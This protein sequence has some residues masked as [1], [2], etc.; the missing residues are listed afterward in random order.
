VNNVA[1]HRHGR[2]RPWPAGHITD[3]SLQRVLIVVALVS[4]AV[5]VWDVTMGGF[6]VRI[7]GLRVVSRNIY[8]PLRNAMICF[9][10]ALWLRDR[11][12]NDR[13]SWCAV[14]RLAPPIAALAAI[15]SAVL[16]I[17]YG[18][19]AAG[20][21]DAFG[22]VSQS[23]LWASGR[24]TE[25]DSF[26]TLSTSLGRAV[27]P[28]GYTLGRTPGV[29]IPTYPPGLP[30]AMALG[31]IVGGPHGVYFVV[32]LLAG[33]AVW[34]TYLL[35]ARVAGRA[36]GATAALLL[37]S[38][39]IFIFQSFQPMSDVPATT[40]WLLS[41]ALAVTPATWA[42][43]AAGAAASAAVLTRPNLVP[44]AVVVALVAA[45]SP[46]RWRRAAFFAAAF[47]PGCVAIGVL[48]VSLY[49]SPL[50]SGYGPLDSL[51]AWNNVIA[52]AR[53][54]SSWLLD[55]QSP[56]ILLALAAPLVTRVKWSAAMFAFSAFLVVS[57]LFYG[58]FDNW[59]F[60]RFLLPAIPLLLI[61]VAAV[62]VAA[63]ERLPI[64]FRGSALFLVCV[65][66][67]GWCLVKADQLKAFDIYRAERRYVS[68]GEFI[69]S[70]L[71][72]NAVVITVIESG[73]VRLYGHRPTLRWDYIEPQRFDDAVALVRARG[74][75]P[76]ILLEFWEEPL[77]RSRFA[78]TSA[79]G[80]V[81]WPAAIQYFGVLDVRVYAV[82]DRP[83]YLTG[84]RILPAIVPL[85]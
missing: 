3:S 50:R 5:V 34:L 55:L 53:N 23:A 78:S 49:G 79:I 32:P 66:A 8:K 56:A 46:P 16:A 65:L 26:A 72:P 38:S 42:A 1:T 39:P 36:A 37:A 48:N 47:V 77:F 17:R 25:H 13:T 10:A 84:Q 12:A 35:G 69:G 30:L 76:Y 2:T 57:Y 80:S 11:L 67:S 21:S 40:W 75:A 61:F 18:I 85:D 31:S 68:V 71:P 73:S 70:R 20:G 41:W 15:F 58:V 19:F 29:L 9:V 51:F 43:A 59:T 82:D 7:L 81:D 22:Y 62:S 60:L 74:Y 6:D 63:I 52:N 83:R 28:L 14:P 4:F 27:T 45:S 64:A 54:Y 24:V 33:L 44:L